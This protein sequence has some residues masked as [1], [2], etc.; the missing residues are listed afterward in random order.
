M[1][2]LGFWLGLP[3]GAWFGLPSGAWFV[4]TKGCVV[5]PFFDFNDLSGVFFLG[6][7]AKDANGFCFAKDVSGF[8]FVWEFFAT[9][10][11]AVSVMPVHNTSNGRKT[12]LSVDLDLWIDNKVPS[13]DNIKEGYNIIYKIF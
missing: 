2:A 12:R 13:P 4:L 9:A 6:C 7:F 8:C 1:V 5:L 11:S 3:S 10:F